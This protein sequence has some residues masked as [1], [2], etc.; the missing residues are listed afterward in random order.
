MT[1]EV[2]RGE[3]PRPRSSGSYLWI[4]FGILAAAAFVGIIV[5]ASAKRVIQ[6]PIVGDHW[7]ARFTVSVCGKTLPPLPPSAGGVHT[8]G[9]GAIHIHPETAAE[10]G[11]NA[12]LG[13]FLKTVRIVVT[14]TSLQLA[15]GTVF[16]NGDACPGGKP[17]AVRLL[18]N[19]APNDAWDRYALRNNDRIVVSFQ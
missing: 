6:H 1:R 9:D 5:S 13:L 18:I 12:N 7:H 3:K 17:G 16:R 2:K 19:G 11:S 4:V 15:D 14:P 10:S 8:H